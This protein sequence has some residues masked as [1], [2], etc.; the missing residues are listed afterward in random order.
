MKSLTPLNKLFLGVALVS[1]LAGQA[2]VAGTL[3]LIG[4]GWPDR[5]VTYEVSASRN[6]SSAAVNAVLGAIND[7]NDYLQG[8]DG[9]PTLVPF[10]G[11]GKPDV[12]IQ[13]KIGGGSVLGQT[14]LRPVN[15]FS[16]II[17]S[18]RVLLSGK[19]FGQGFSVVGI[20]NVAR[21]EIGHVLGLGH[22]D[23][24]NDLMYFAAESGDIF[25]EDPEDISRCDLDGLN[26][27]YPVPEDC[28]I[29]P[30]VECP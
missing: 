18:A 22:S 19:A 30:S 6:V 15:R 17:G 12:S 8:I 11:P 16:C 29:P 27:I 10:T 26:A 23:D 20:G 7:W 2:T 25:G 28:S 24:P 1:W 14:S 3:D 21:H 9:A 5:D 4:G 13:L